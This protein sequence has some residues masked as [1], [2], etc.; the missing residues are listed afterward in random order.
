MVVVPCRRRVLVFAFIFLVA[1]A[2]VCILSARVHVHLRLHV[3]LHVRVAS[4][5]AVIFNDNELPLLQHHLMRTGAR[6]DRLNPT[7]AAGGSWDTQITKTTLPF[8]YSYQPGS[9]TGSS[10]CFFF[11]F[12]V[13][14][15]GIL[16]L[17]QTR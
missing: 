7:Q 11:F 4:E 9:T 10:N 3:R 13:G 1:F 16:N 8:T 2:F 14:V 17:V 12:F 15:G 5:V 6:E